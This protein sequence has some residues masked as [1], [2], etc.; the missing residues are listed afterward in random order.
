[1]RVPFT[2]DQFF[3]VFAQYNDAVWPAQLLL[4]LLAIVAVALVVWP[5]AQSEAIV[6]GI[7]AIL[8][9]WLGLVYHLMFF[10][11][12]N[13]LAYVFAAV[14]VLAAVGFLWCGVVWRR[15]RFARPVGWRGWTGV[16]LLIYALLIYPAL[17]WFSGHSYLA[18]PTF[19]L[20]CPTTIFTVG[21]LAFMTAPFPRLLFVVPV[22]W[23]FV[24]GQAAFVLS[25]PQDFGLLVAG[26][27]GVILASS[28][29]SGASHVQ[30]SL[31]SRGQTA[32]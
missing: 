31:P 13:P 7:L 11:R 28:S 9:A 30:T 2:V 17:S 16:S 22:L 6:S 1:M 5:R 27:V 29:R 4:L 12:I 20:P 15:V 26:V 10:S 25:V 21:L 32:G 19:G 24:G 18:S 23:S 14:S 3:A 8:W